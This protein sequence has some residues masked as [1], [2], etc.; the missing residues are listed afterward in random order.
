MKQM[1][2]RLSQLGIKTRRC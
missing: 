2:T 1:K